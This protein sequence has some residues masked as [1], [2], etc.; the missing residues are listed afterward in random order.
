MKEG[1]GLEILGCTWLHSVALEGLTV[2]ITRFLTRGVD[3]C[4]LKRHDHTFRKV[5]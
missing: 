1:E 4:E 5:L 2:Y 3:I